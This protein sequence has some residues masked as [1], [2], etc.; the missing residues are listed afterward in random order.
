VGGVGVSCGAAAFDLR[1]SIMGGGRTT[2]GAGAAV[3]VGVGVGMGAYVRRAR[4]RG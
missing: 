1:G 3:G 2:A 4:L